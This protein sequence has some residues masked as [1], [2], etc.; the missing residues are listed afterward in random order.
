[1]DTT[2][3][4]SFLPHDAPED[5]RPSAAPLTGPARPSSCAGSLLAA[6]DLDG[7]VER[8][9]AG[10]AEVVAAIPEQTDGTAKEPRARRRWRASPGPWGVRLQRR[11]P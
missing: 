2:I 4:A 5:A 3:H 10:G 11:S 6:A 8:V 1:M 7:T 9:R